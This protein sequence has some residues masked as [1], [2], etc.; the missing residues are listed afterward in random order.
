MK[1]SFITVMSCNIEP[2]I[3]DGG[4]E[5]YLL[6]GGNNEKGKK[7]CNDRSIHIFKP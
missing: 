7:Y 5:V 1:P 3:L 2:T 4:V 6:D